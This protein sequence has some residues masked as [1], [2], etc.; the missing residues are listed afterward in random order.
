MPLKRP[1]RSWGPGPEPG[2]GVMVGEM[3]G[4]QCETCSSEREE[5]ERYWRC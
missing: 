4:V 1:D 5:D 3:E 2:P